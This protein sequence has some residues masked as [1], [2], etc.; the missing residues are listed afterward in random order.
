MD[1]RTRILRPNQPI[2]NCQ[3]PG[4]DD[5]NTF[6]LGVIRGARILSSG[7]FMKE[8]SPRFPGAENS[9]RLRGMAT[10]KDFQNLGFGRMI[11][12]AAQFELQKRNCD[13]LW[14]NARVSAEIFYRKMGFLAVEE[15]FD[16]PLA[17]PHKVMYKRFR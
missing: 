11:I 7:T 6:H 16:I 3:Y 17:G 15:I 5:V 8:M 1:L 4:D 10:D 14:F 13:L 2:E 12:E 9:Y